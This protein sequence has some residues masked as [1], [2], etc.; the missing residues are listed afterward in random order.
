MEFK[1][2]EKQLNVLLNYLATKPYVE[3]FQ[4]VQMLTTLSQIEEEKSIE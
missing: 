3:V 2:E 4:I 1:I